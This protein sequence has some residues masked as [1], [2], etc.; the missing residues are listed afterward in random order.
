M[1]I[2]PTILA[3]TGLLVWVDPSVR[4]AHIKP[5]QRSML[6]LMNNV[7]FMIYMRYTSAYSKDGKPKRCLDRKPNLHVSCLKVQTFPPT[8]PRL[9]N[10]SVHKASILGFPALRHCNLRIGEGHCLGP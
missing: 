4:T 6:E 5:D 2:T 7:P 3:A 10:K 8:L 9:P 1:E